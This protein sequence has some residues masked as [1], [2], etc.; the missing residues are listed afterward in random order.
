M[1][2]VKTAGSGS[3]LRLSLAAEAWT[4]YEP[5]RRV[6]SPDIPGKLQGASAES[7]IGHATVYERGS[8]DSNLITAGF[9]PTFDIE[10]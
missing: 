5:L 8:H 2:T 7:P 3:V 9:R 1:P 6:D 4:L 10:V